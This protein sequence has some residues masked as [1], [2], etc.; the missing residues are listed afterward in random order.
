MPAIQTALVQQQ[1]AQLSTY[2]ADPPAY[3]PALEKMLENYV[4]PVQRQGRTR[5][6]RPILFSYETPAPVLKQLQL[7]LT[8]QA[9]QK[10][11]Q[12]LAIAD[13]LWAKRTI[14][15]RLLAA[16]LLGSIPG[17]TANDYSSR[18]EDWS[19]ENRELILAPELTERAT[20]AFC[21]QFP[22][23][24]VAFVRR[25]LAETEPRKQVF[26]L[27]AL[28]TLLRIDHFG[29]LPAIFNLLTK[30][31]RDPDKK[32]RSA[33]V[34]VLSTLAVRSSKETTYF[35]EQLLAKKPSESAQWL[36]R[37]VAKAL[38]EESRQSLRQGS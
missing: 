27:G 10:P 5:S 38:P 36:A 25:L 37:Q 4:V 1:A 21:E 9:K 14:E 30:I 26:A 7:E 34:E 13:A 17:L 31:A 15:T 32:M 11:Q 2:F 8:Y 35:L 18:L 22:D 29:D 28:N 3:V 12:A 16:R 33:L 19:L 20:L 24:L 6:A 23:K